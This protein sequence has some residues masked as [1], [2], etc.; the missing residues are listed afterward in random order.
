M[1]DDE[2]WLAFYYFWKLQYELRGN[3]IKNRQKFAKKRE[4]LTGLNSKVHCKL[5]NAAV[6]GL[7]KP[8]DNIF[9]PL[10]IPDFPCFGYNSNCSH[11]KHREKI[12]RKINKIKQYANLKHSLQDYSFKD[13]QLIIDS[14]NFLIQIMLMKQKDISGEILLNTFIYDTPVKRKY[15]NAGIKLLGIENLKITEA[16]HLSGKVIAEIDLTCSTS[17]LCLRIESLK[18][19][20]FIKIPTF[21]KLHSAFKVENISNSTIEKK[22]IKDNPDMGCQ[23]NSFESRAIG[24]WLYDAVTTKQYADFG[25]AYEALK[26][27]H[28]RDNKL[29][30]GSEIPANA[31]DILGKGDSERRVITRL[32]EKTENCVIKREVL[33]LK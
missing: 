17:F 18:S 11:C 22:I 13:N 26:N 31:L 9:I 24:L 2:K 1:T 30:E 27:G 14:T 29:L 21:D 28:W 5:Y 20:K 8:G 10:F 12:I 19:L 23:T 6:N 33:T 15:I 32:Y 16:M 25:E 3:L 4:E 7:D